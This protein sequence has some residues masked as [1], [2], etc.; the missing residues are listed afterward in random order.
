MKLKNFP[1]AIALT[2]TICVSTLQVVNAGAPASASTNAGAAD[3]KGVVKFEGVPPK[4]K[5]ISM[6]ADPSCAKQHSGLVTTLDVATDS[7]GGLQNVLVFISDGLG[8]RTFDPPKEPVVITQKGCLYEP[9]V[10]AVQANQPIEVVNDDPTSHNI[11]PTPANNR[12]WNKAELPGAKVEEA[13]AREEIAIPVRCNIH[14]WMR[15]YI[16]VLKNPYF[17]VTKPDGSFELSNLPPGTYT[18]KAWHEKLG[19]STQTITIGANQ[20]K[21]INFVFKSM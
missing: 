13:F 2:L 8:D 12:E 20:T 3:V 19:T 15:G 7:K 4:G 1:F 6:A 9:R 21:E 10:M 16:A 17:A 5:P 18:I 11:H 14:P